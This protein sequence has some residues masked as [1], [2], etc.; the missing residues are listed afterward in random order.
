VAAYTLPNGTSTIPTR[1]VGP[2]AVPTKVAALIAKWETPAPPAKATTG[3]D[4][5]ITVP[6]AAFANSSAAPLTTA[7][8]VV[9]KDYLT[10]GT[11]LMHNGGNIYKPEA[12][13]L[14]YQ[15]DVGTAGT[16]YLTA[17]H[18]TWHTDQ[19]LMLAVNGKKMPHVPVFLTLGY[20]NETQPVEVA[21]TKGVNTLTFTRLSTTQCSFKE[22]FLYTEKPDIPAPPGGGFTPKPI[23]PP[24]PASAFILEPPST[25]CILQGIKNVPEE[26]CEEACLLV[27]NRS[28]TGPR[29]GTNV[30][31]CFAIMS[32]PYKGNCNYNSNTS[33]TCT[34]P[35]GPDDNL[36][37][38]CL[39]GSL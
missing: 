3:A 16:Y 15:V 4:G 33:S 28:Y 8:V 20:W 30:R 12:A 17:N 23:T 19:D 9:M 35:C 32:G 10:S 31:G 26:L 25:A 14:V 13:A 11:Q 21:L 34:P 5:T 18:S 37:E 39:T 29:A 1:P 36:G 38:I 2:S 27:A 24:L 22:F 7:N 6:A